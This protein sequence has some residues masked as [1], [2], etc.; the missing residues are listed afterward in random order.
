MLR[1]FTFKGIDYC[2]TLI[3]C[4]TSISAPLMAASFKL[5]KPSYV[6]GGTAKFPYSLQPDDRNNVYFETFI[7]ASM[8]LWKAK[9]SKLSVFVKG[10]YSK[11]SQLLTF[12]NRSKAS[13][14][15]SYNKKLHKNFNVT[16][17]FQYGYDYRP[18]SNKTKSGFR[19][20]LS[21]FYYKSRW[22]N[23]PRGHKGW[24]RQKS[25]A[26]AWGQFT[27]PES[28]DAGNH[29]LAF[30][31]GLEAA[32]AF[33]RPRGKLQYVPFAELT[34][35]RDSYKLSFNNKVVPAV[36]FKFRYPIKGGQINLGIKYAVDRRWIKGT[37]EYGTV[38]FAGW[39]KTF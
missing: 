26:R 5:P 29:N 18:L 31:T 2:L 15:I 37:T 33:V 28:L 35:A 34:L 4:V 10:F 6:T 11:D 27:F 16:A 32:V 9:K 12:N 38:I 17:T 3:L 25:W 39:Y 24:F 19:A 1:L 7:K 13:V 20:N 21:Y 23:M 14:G 30:I 36:G 22:R 8:P